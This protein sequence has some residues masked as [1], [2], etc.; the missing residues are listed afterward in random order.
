MHNK[1][2]FIARVFFIDTQHQIHYNTA[3]SSIKFITTTSQSI[4]IQYT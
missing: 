3:P 4:D 2:R 1:L